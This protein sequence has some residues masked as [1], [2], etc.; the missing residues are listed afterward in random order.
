M[1]KQIGKRSMR[2][3]IFIWLTLFL[4]S[5]SYTPKEPALLYEEFINQK[6]TP[7]ISN[8]K[9]EGKLAIPNFMSWGIFNYT[10]NKSYIDTLLNFNGFFEENE[11]NKKFEKDETKY[12]P[13]DLSFWT[14]HSKRKYK[15]DFKKQNCIYLT[16][17]NFPYIHEILIDTTSY[18]VLHLI[19]TMRD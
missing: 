2:T 10:C 13:T 8:L 5:C 18:E 6:P 17:I 4:G 14:E 19:S 3:G 11:F 12:F 16:G 15:T 1:L 7:N 9:G